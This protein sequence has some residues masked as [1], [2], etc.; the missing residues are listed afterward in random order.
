[1]KIEA[2]LLVGRVP[3]LD[4]VRGI[5]IIMVVVFHLSRRFMPN[6]W[7]G[8]DVFFVLSGYL[9]T[10]LLINE[11]EN[12]GSI[13]LK[14]FYARRALRLI[15]A[16]SVLLAIYSFV[17]A[18]QG[19]SLS[20]IARTVAVVHLYCSNIAIAFHWPIVIDSLGPMWSLS[21]EEQFYFVWP[22]TLIGLIRI[23]SYN[24]ICRILFFLV[25]CIGIWR[26]YLYWQTGSFDRCYFSSDT[27]ADALLVGC[28]VA[29]LHRRKINISNNVAIL[30]ALAFGWLLLTDAWE[31]PSMFYGRFTAAGVCVGLLLLWLVQREGTIAHRVLRMT[32]LTWVGRISYSL[33]IWHASLIADTGDFR[34]S[35]KWATVSIFLLSLIVAAIS[36]YYVE[37]PF[38]K[39]RYKVIYAGKASSGLVG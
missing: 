14:A 30:A 12:K 13:E 32:A 20:Q 25:C 1:M 22:I 9:I 39:L 31:S 6:G 38:M 15:P 34:R 29:F 18:A 2:P 23:R 24:A 8:V 35:S 11:Y 4:G 19:V 27:R 17:R 28:M 3:E 33:Y 26:G 7:L 36:Y 16:V 5:S 10:S 37:I 21:L